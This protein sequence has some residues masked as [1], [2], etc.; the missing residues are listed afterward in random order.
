MNCTKLHYLAVVCLFPAQF[1]LGARE[2]PVQLPEQT[3]AGWFYLLETGDS[4]VQRAA[5]KAIDE[6]V[7][8]VASSLDTESPQ[9]ESFFFDRN[10]S[11]CIDTLS[12]FTNRRNARVREKIVQ[13]V[14]L[15][16]MAISIDIHR[17]LKALTSKEKSARLEAARKICELS[18]FARHAVFVIK[19]ASLDASDTEQQQAKEASE[20]F[21]NIQKDAIPVLN[22]S[23]KHNRAV[24]LD[25][26][27]ALGFL[28]P[29]P[30]AVAHSEK[31]TL[32]VG[33]TIELDG[34]ASTDPLGSP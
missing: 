26:A 33:D 1:G 25:A 4:R 30:I 14:A 5:S 24:R 20:V 10:L 34:S 7:E 9:P 2:E 8:F 29:Q 16:Q 17:R 3:F 15:F 12:H 19:N 31:E 32:V 13:S 28:L 23:L 18:R 11:S 21:E 6:I 27:M 22:D